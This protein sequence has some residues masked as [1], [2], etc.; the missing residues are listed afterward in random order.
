[1][2]LEITLKLSVEISTAIHSA[3]DQKF[4]SQAEILQILSKISLNFFDNSFGNSF[5]KS[6][7]N[8]SSISP[9]QVIRNRLVITVRIP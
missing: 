5:E 8:P 3:L 7:S 9:V 2:P 6:F 1:M 4:I